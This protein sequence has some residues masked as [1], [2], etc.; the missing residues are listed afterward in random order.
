MLRNLPVQVDDSLLVGYESS[1]DA[2]VYRIDGDRAVVTTV[3]F[4][5]PPVDDPH[6][7]GRIAA[8]NSIS[9]IYAM[10]ARPLFALNLV[11]FPAGK[12]GQEVLEG[13]LRGAADK[14]KEAGAVLAGG[15]SVDDEEPKFGLCV[16]GIAGIG[17]ILRNDGALPGDAIV[18]TKP[19][20]TGVLFNAAKARK[21]PAKELD[22]I[23]PQVAKL[24]ADGLEVLREH[25]V[26]AL[27]DVTGFGIAGHLVEMARSSD[28]TV[29]VAHRD[30]PLYPGALEMYEIGQTTGSNGPNRVNVRDHIRVS[31]L[32][33]PAGEE[34]LYD[35]Q[36]SGG[37]LA[38]VPKDA[39][40][41]AVKK[42]REKGYPAS[43]VIGEVVSR[44]QHHIIVE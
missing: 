13:I 42:L 21:F 27:T 16:T 8:A 39:C 43:A 38:A 32:L 40:R 11:M 36:T 5:T 23:L 12:L 7:F 28:V 35:P 24:N 34:I 41:D 29:R 1:D 14:V 18:L 33:P 44:E 2:A 19:L 31:G 25:G 20:G 37:L 6:W 22:A 26:R 4:I 10:G 9:D 15:H 17:E 30:L 3:D